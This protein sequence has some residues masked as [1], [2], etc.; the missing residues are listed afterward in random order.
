MNFLT[1]VFNSLRGQGGLGQS[2]RFFWF[3]HVVALLIFFSKWAH[4]PP[5]SKRLQR[6][7]V[8]KMG[9]FHAFSA[10]CMEK[11]PKILVFR[12]PLSVF[13]SIGSLRDPHFEFS[14]NISLIS[15]K[16][17]RGFWIFWFFNL[18]W[19]VLAQILADFSNF[20]QIFKIPSV[21]L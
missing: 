12:N 21:I 4:S 2:L 9:R 17:Q 7:G 15:T 19:A 16:L 3:W 13:L 6:Y 1:Y 20:G 11:W 8:S 10:I 14:D 5:N 18:L